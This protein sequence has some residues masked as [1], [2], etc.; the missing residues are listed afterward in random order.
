MSTILG[1]HCY[2]GDRNS[3]AH[4]LDNRWIKRCIQSRRVATGPPLS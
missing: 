4:A 2:D 3:N 1:S